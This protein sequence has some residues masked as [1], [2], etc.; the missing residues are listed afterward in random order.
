VPVSVLLIDDDPTFRAL[1]RRVLSAAGLQVV[2]E[3][4]TAACGVS[5]AL[6]L[7]PEAL[8]VDVGLPDR[9]GISLAHEL[10]A[11]PWRPRVVLAS[12]DPDAAGA[13]DIKSSGACGF[14]PKHDL[15]GSGLRLLLGEKVFRTH[16]DGR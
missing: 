12:V 10:S 16:G 15:P 4:D 2:G 8:L 3:A 6:E 14:A 13:D 11:L 9:D 7:R 5:A 1:A